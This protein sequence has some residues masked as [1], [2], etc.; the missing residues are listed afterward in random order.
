MAAMQPGYGAP[1]S[2]FAVGGHVYRGPQTLAQP[3]RAASPQ[4]GVPLP[5]TGSSRDRSSS[6]GVTSPTS[7]GLPLMARTGPRAAP[8]PDVDFRS[9]VSFGNAS[10]E[11]Y[12]E[13]EAD[14]AVSDLEL[15]SIY[16]KL[17][18]NSNGV[19]SKLE[20]IAAVSQDKS[21]AQLLG[22]DGDS[23]LSDEKSFDELHSIF[24]EISAGKKGIDYESFCKHVRKAKTDKT[25]RS[26]RMQE[27]FNLIDADGSGSISKLELV[28]AM[29]N[30][31]AVDEF[32]MPGVDSSRI[33]DDENLFEKIDALFEVRHAESMENVRVHALDRAFGNLPA[34]SY[35]LGKRLLAMMSL[36]LAVCSSLRLLCFD[37]D[38]FGPR[39]ELGFD[40]S[41]S[42]KAANLEVLGQP[43]LSLSVVATLQN[44][45]TMINSSI[46]IV[47]ITMITITTTIFLY[48]LLMAMVRLTHSG[49]WKGAATVLRD[50]Y[51]DTLRLPRRYFKA[52]LSDCSFLQKDP[53]LIVFSPRRR[54]V[55]TRE[56]MPQLVERTPMAPRRVSGRGPL[57]GPVPGLACENA[58]DA[59]R[60]RAWDKQMPRLGIASSSLVSW[61]KEPGVNLPAWISGCRAH[62]RYLAERVME[63]ITSSMVVGCGLGRLSADK[64]AELR[65]PYVGVWEPCLT[66]AN[67]EVGRTSFSFQCDSDVLAPVP[68]QTLARGRILF[69]L[70]GDHCDER[71]KPWCSQ[72]GVQIDN[73]CWEPLCLEYDGIQPHTGGQLPSENAVGGG[74]VLRAGFD[75]YLSNAEVKRCYFDPT[76][77]AFDIPVS[78]F[79]PQES[80]SSGEVRL[81]SA[82]STDHGCLT[83]RD[84]RESVTHITNM[85]YGRVSSKLTFHQIL[86][87]VADALPHWKSEFQDTY[88]EDV[89]EVET[90]EAMDPA[91][92]MKAVN[93]RKT[94]GAVAR[95][96]SKPLA[97]ALQ[98]AKCSVPCRRGSANE[99]RK[100]KLAAMRACKDYD[101]SEPGDLQVSLKSFD[102]ACREALE[103][104]CPDKRLRISKDAVQVLLTGASEA[105][106][107]LMADADALR[108]HS[109]PSGHFSARKMGRCHAP[110]S[111]NRSSACY[112]EYENRSPFSAQ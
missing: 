17:D 47:I 8:P 54:A 110:R 84:V 34:V 61:A 100:A 78:M 39:Q 2:H 48:T 56:A 93:F 21:I 71:E 87:L 65:N 31:V 98:E 95:A 62:I 42:F 5:K 80:D 1:A 109:S 60:G 37:V 44:I 106:A 32:L 90:A 73:A 22:I 101:N 40:R 51:Y 81:A 103:T 53:Q 10:Y 107:Q 43:V 20:L 29:Q 19:V 27:I 35:E 50:Y 64:L 89:D 57:P 46:A 85:A 45:T 99:I 92:A 13:E 11:Q 18:K 94:L 16:A 15:R 69:H 76:S 104:V 70:L 91:A 97:K 38:T 77:G 68:A 49:Y 4:L 23:L 28:A 112:K 66:R 105:L 72:S 75:R 26:N 52:Q 14:P 24:E 7:P 33:M 30:N 3:Y 67:C 36:G 86:A 111:A 74:D 79:V 58:G 6:P 55:R 96:K 25:P 12:T 9:G 59:D 63:T 102:G 108:L 88:A 83:S 41:Q 82:S